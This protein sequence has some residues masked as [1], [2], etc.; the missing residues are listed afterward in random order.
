VLNK[1]NTAPWRRRGEWMYISTFLVGGEWSASSL[2]RSTPEPN[3]IEGWVDPKVDLDDMERKEFM[4]LRDSNSDPSVVQPVTSRYTATPV[5]P[6]AMCCSQCG[7]RPTMAYTCHL[8]DGRWNHFS[9]LLTEPARWQTMSKKQ[10][11]SSL[12]DGHCLGLFLCRHLFFFK[13]KNKKNKTTQEEERV[14]VL[15]HGCCYS[16]EIC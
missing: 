4:T 10:H 14:L 13:A 11:S 9:I 8:Y 7:N 1:L 3:C 15:R 6:G 2:C 16:S 5:D 12:P